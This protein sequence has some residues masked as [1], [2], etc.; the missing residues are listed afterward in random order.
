LLLANGACCLIW[1]AVSSLREKADAIQLLSM[2]DRKA[3][4]RMF[5]EGV[6][7]DLFTPKVA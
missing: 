4:A 2:S 5:F 1:L 3:M 6:V 7:V